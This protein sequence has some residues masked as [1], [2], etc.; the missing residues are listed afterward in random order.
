MSGATRVSRYEISIAPNL[1]ED[2]RR[3][4]GASRLADVWPYQD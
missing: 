2:L 1:I 4:L 3:R